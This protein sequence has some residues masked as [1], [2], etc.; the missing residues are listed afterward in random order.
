MNDDFLYKFRKPPRR[1]FA[2]ALYQRIAKPMK[3]N[4][5]ILALR[6]FALAF[7][8]LAILA[9]VMFF[10]PTTRAMVDS[11]IRR[12]GGIIFVQATPQP[13]PADIGK[14]IAGPNATISPDQQVTMQ[15]KKKMAQQAT[16]SPQERAS[17]Q[18][19]QQQATLQATESVA[20]DANAVSGLVGFTVLAPAYLPDGYTAVPGGWKVSQGNDVG[21]STTTQLMG[22]QAWKAFLEALSTIM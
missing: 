22:K 18:A 6:A 2:V 4:S 1:E 13:D 5:R 9:G 11:V 10:S 12:I 21:D 7:S 19:K 16:V 20:L 17:M 14:G 3:T 15:A 8:L